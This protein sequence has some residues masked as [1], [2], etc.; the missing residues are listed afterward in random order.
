MHVD[1]QIKTKYKTERSPVHLLYVKTTSQTVAK[2][3]LKNTIIHKEKDRKACVQPP[4]PLKQG[5][6]RL[7]TGLDQ[8]RQLKIKW[9]VLK[10]IFV[11]PINL[12]CCPCVSYS[13]KLAIFGPS[14]PWHQPRKSLRTKRMSELRYTPITKNHGGITWWIAVDGRNVAINILVTIVRQ[15]TNKTL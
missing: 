11:P 4:P 1:R 10:P 2:V 13:H 9:A 7:Q 15:T 14:Y 8:I 12:S 3:L 6:G 5:R